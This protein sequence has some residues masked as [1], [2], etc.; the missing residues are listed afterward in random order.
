MNKKSL[1]TLQIARRQ[2]S[3]A[4]LLIS[5][6]RVQNV[7][8]QALHLKIPVAERHDTFK[9]YVHAPF[10]SNLLILQQVQ[11]NQN[12]LFIYIYSCTKSEIRMGTWISKYDIV[13]DLIY[14]KSVY[15]R[16]W[17]S[18]RFTT[19]NIMCEKKNKRYK[20]NIIQIISNIHNYTQR[21]GEGGGRNSRDF[22]VTA[23][24][25]TVYLV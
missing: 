13:L 17:L 20:L 24:Y 18:T 19:Y 7:F 22:Y 10:S 4:Y 9:A 8:W 3:L 14:C 15:L 21:K 23:Y 12:F 6:Q 5:L 1:N 16:R 25:V 11:L 2:S